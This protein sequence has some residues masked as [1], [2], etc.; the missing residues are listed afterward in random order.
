M[1]RKKGALVPLEISILAACFGLKSGGAQEAHGFLIAKQIGDQRGARMLTSHGTLYKALG[2]MA[3]AGLLKSR[4]EDP[5]VAAGESRP[6]R[7]F[8]RVTAEG[9]AALRTAE[10]RQLKAPGV[11]VTA[12][13]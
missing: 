9:Q 4:W 8:Y 7:R 11:S 10:T 3:K 1:R 12:L 13:V 2:R 5:V 6:R